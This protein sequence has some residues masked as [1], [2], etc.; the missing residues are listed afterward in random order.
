VRG[1]TRVPWP[2]AR[3]IALVMSQDREGAVG[4]QLF[5]QGKLHA[6]PVDVTT[7]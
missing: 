3:I 4:N 5:Q 7:V 1:R 2:A 6:C